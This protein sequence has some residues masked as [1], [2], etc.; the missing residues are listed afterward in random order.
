VNEVHVDVV[1]DDAC[2]LSVLD[3]AFAVRVS[4]SMQFVL[5]YTHTIVSHNLHVFTVSGAVTGAVACNVFTVLSLRLRNI[6]ACT[7]ESEISIT[8]ATL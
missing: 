5:K 3:I 7:H 6:R 2:G 1:C 8:H 4:R